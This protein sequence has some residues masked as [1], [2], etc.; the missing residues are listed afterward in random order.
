[1]R[2]EYLPI[3]K[4]NIPYRFDIALPIEIYTFEVRY[5]ETYDFFTIDLFKGDETLVLG[6]KIVYGV[7]LF[8]DVYDRR[9]PAPTIVPLDESG[10]EQHVTYKNL[11]ETVFLVVMNR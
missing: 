6:E 10:N 3:E 7:P 9:F 5:N 1:M 4:E 2:F 8:R 11:G